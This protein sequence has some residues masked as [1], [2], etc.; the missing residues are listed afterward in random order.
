MHGTNFV[1][2]PTRGA[3]VVTVHD[4]AFFRDPHLVSA[5]SRRYAGSLRVA[6]ARGATV[7]VFSDTVGDEVRTGYDL[8]SDRVVRIYPGIA[9]SVRGDDTGEPRPDGRTP[10]RREY[11]LALGTVEPRKNLPRLVAAFDRRRRVRRRGPARRRRSRRLGHRRVHH[12][13]P[14][15]RPTA[16][17]H[18]ARLRRRRGA[19][20]PSRRRVGPRVPVARRRLRS[21]A[22]RGDARRRSRRR[23]PGRVAPRGAR[24]R[25]AA[26]RPGIGRGARDALTESSTDPRLPTASSPPA[27]SACGATRGRAPTD[28]LVELVPTAHP[29][30]RS[31]EDL[32]VE[33]AEQRRDR[34]RVVAQLVAGAADQPQLP[35]SPAGLGEQARVV[36]GTTGR[37][38]CRARR[39][40]GAAR[41]AGPRPGRR[42]PRPPGST[43][44]P[45]AGSPGVRTMPTRRAKSSS[46]AGSRPHSR[47][48]S[49]AASAA[50]PAPA[51]RPRRRD[52]QRAPFGDAH[53]PHACVSSTRSRSSVAARMSASQPADREVAVGRAG[54]AEVEGEREPAALAG[55]AVG[56]LGIRAR[57]CRP[58]RAGPWGSR[59]R[60]RRRAPAA[61]LG[62]PSARCAPSLM[63]SERIVAS[64]PPV[65]SSVPDAGTTDSTHVPHSRNG[66]SSC[67]R[68]WPASRSST[69]ARAGSAKTVA[70]SRFG[71]PACG[72]TPPSS[73]RSATCSSPRTA[74]GSTTPSATRHA[75]RAIRIE[76]WADIVG[77]AQ[78]TEP[79]DLAKIDGKFIWTGDYAASRLSWK[80]RDPL[81]VLALRAHRLAE[82]ITVPWRDEY[83]GCTSWV[84]LDGLPDDPASAAVASPRCPTARSKR[85]S[86]S[87]P[88]T[89][90]RL[91]RPS[92]SDQ[93]TPVD[94]AFEALRSSGRAVAAVARL[95]QR[96]G[97]ERGEL[98]RRH[99]LVDRRRHRRVVVDEVEVVDALGPL[100]T[101]VAASARSGSVRLMRATLVTRQLAGT[102]TPSHGPSAASGTDFAGGAPIRCVTGGTNSRGVGAGA[103]VGIPPG[104][105]AERGPSGRAPPGSHVDHALCGPPPFP[106]PDL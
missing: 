78:L 21:P 98:L 27:T 31:L 58:H 23:G 54:A 44:S 74:A 42:R 55:D 50:H 17:G 86:A 7:H 106:G 24:R 2:P 95:G 65:S 64:R 76:G 87:R 59:G 12:R 34:T 30:S 69:S 45:T 88:T 35:A 91:R 75:D 16:P 103:A 96:V 68:C 84:D 100:V 81:W 10:V 22:A 25:R 6:I 70:T 28:E 46:R 67:A 99:D 61:A 60:A 32:A 56:E 43:R 40:A 20:R 63:P 82:P 39:A 13:G 19:P 47:S 105:P 41:S 53:E 15:S 71:P 62:G 26:R 38:P 90:R 66:R 102:D 85:A 101:E 8:P 33:P 92:R 72:S 37:R 83:G 89:S 36:D 77:V 49:G 52:R 80:K 51:G 104:S 3:A 73:T 48:V 97:R 93:P 79:D 94:S 9:A 11:V 57:R 29:S 1:V 14:R 18:P 5:A 4:V